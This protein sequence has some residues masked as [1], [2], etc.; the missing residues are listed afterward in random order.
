MV[1]FRNSVID[2]DIVTENLKKLNEFKHSLFSELQLNRL[3]LKLTIII[4][5]GLTKIS[6]EAKNF[7]I[8]LFIIWIDY[9]RDAVTGGTPLEVFRTNA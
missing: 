6:E 9:K 8:F 2:C 4:C 7:Y 5:N 1:M 3:W